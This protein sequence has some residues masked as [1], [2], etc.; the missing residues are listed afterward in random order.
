[1]DLHEDDARG[2]L[3]AAQD[4]GGLRRVPRA[5]QWRRILT[6]CL[7]VDREYGPGPGWRDVSPFDAGW[8]R[9]VGADGER[10]VVVDTLDLLRVKG[11]GGRGC[12]GAA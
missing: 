4:E 1:M 10:G 5:Q 12:M 9:G 8:Q 6:R 2:Q 7:A 11:G 3:G